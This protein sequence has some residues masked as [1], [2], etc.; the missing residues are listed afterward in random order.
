LASE[1]LIS[2]IFGP[3]WQGEGQQA[4]RLAAFVRFATCNLACSWCDT[5][6]AVFFDEHKA[7]YHQDKKAYD[8]K[9][10]IQRMPA[11]EVA[12]IVTS[13]PIPK[14]TLIVI[15]GGEPM[16]Q[17]EGIIELCA[18]LADRG[19]YYYA[20]E[21]AGTRSA[22]RLAQGLNL[23]QSMH[24][25]VSPKLANS[26]NPYNRRR[27]P[28][29]L[30]EYNRFGS[31]FKFVVKVASDLNEV[32]DIVQTV[33]I[34]PNQVWIMPEGTKAGDVVW[35]ARHFRDEVLSRGWNLTLRQQV[36]MFDE[37]RGV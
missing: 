22:S 28:H 32:D 29:I 3:T 11:T 35:N 25:T 17:V 12:E 14:S 2:E 16:L 21:T 36:I 24:V 9:V 26:G 33:G 8:P 34:N 20:L 18:E 10:E 7:S 4:G 6:Y 31:D 37:K 27:M 30:E 13:L 15:S 1:L 23:P 19:Y 5:P